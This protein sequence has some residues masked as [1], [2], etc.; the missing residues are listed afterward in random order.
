M[1][2]DDDDDWCPSDVKEGSFF[3]AE[4]RIRYLCFT[5]ENVLLIFF[6]TGY[7]SICINGYLYRANIVFNDQELII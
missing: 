7:V 5:Y 1:C 4:T 6:S 2:D 3:Y